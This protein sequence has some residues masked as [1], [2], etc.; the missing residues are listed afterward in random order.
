MR[1][2]TSKPELRQELQNCEAYKKLVKALHEAAVNAQAGD[3]E[4]IHDDAIAANQ[5]CE[6]VDKSVQTSGVKTIE[7]LDDTDDPTN[8]VPE[9]SKTD[10]AE[11]ENRTVCFLAICP[12]NSWSLNFKI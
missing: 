7:Q 3:S 12:C 1:I 4:K 9:N 5:D 8:P 10:I 11:K 6:R 2:S